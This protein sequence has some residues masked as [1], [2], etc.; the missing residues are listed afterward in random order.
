MRILRVIR[1]IYNFLI[2]LLKFSSK[3][4]KI[5]FLTFINRHKFCFLCVKGIRSP[6]IHKK[7]A[8]CRV[9]F[10]LD[11]IEQEVK[12]ETE[13]INETHAKWFYSGREGWWQ[14]DDRTSKDI[15][16][17]FQDPDKKQV[18]ISVVGFMYT[19]DFEKEIQFRTS[20]PS[21]HR[22]VKRETS[23][24]ALN[25]KG[26]AG[27]R[28]HEQKPVEQS[29]LD[30]ET[31]RDILEVTNESADEA[32]GS[33]EVTQSSNEV[34]PPEDEL[35]TLVSNLQLQPDPSPNF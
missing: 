19:L 17:A 5:S 26:I 15:E 13:Q 32:T 28:L 9:D 11:S 21:R 2:I 7:C 10:T 20:D 24:V 14:Y 30:G 29:P 3:L 35:T 1:I 27:L 16:E 22:K 23:Q 12:V 31:S 6:S 18:E 4:S 33:Y 8:L 25:V 34:T